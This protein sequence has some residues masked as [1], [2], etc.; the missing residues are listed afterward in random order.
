MNSLVSYLWSKVERGLYVFMLGPWRPPR[1]IQLKT[2]VTKVGPTVSAALGGLQSLGRFTELTHDGNT[3]QA[4]CVSVPVE[5]SRGQ[6][7]LNR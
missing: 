1:V 2:L 6:Q 5:D 7:K 3:A 4:H